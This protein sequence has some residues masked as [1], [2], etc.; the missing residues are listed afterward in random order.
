MRRDFILQLYRASEAA[1]GPLGHWRCTKCLLRVQS[2]IRPVRRCT[3]VPAYSTNNGDWWPADMYA[4]EVFKAGDSGDIVMLEESAL[5]LAEKIEEVLS[6]WRRLTPSVVPIMVT[7]LRHAL[8]W[9][10]LGYHWINTR[11]EYNNDILRFEFL[12]Q[13]TID[14]QTIRYHF[15]LEGSM[16]HAED[17]E[18]FSEV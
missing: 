2:L 3:C 15:R 14:K 5:T 7:K 4:R 13:H 11:P 9:H 8:Q 12:R 16:S 17:G 18:M 10:K 1:T 6:A